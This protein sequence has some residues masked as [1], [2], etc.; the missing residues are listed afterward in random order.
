MANSPSASPEK[1]VFK[2]L[3]D[4]YLHFG[5]PVD[6][7]DEKTDFS[8]HNLKDI[9]A[10]LPYI[11]Q[12]FRPNFFSFVFVKNGSGKYTT[13][14]LVFDTVPGTIYF[15]NPGHYKSYHW[16][17]MEEVYLVTLSE[18]FLKENVHPDVFEEFPF[19][20]AET[21]QPRVLAEAEFAEFEQLYLQINKEYLA[22]S[23]YRNRI[24]GN[25][26][27]VLLLK[28]KEYFWKDYNP[29]YEGNRSSQIVKTFKLS[30]EKHYRDLISHK[31]EHVF[32]VQDYA[33]E[34]FLHPNYLSNVI[35]IKTGKPIGTWIAE[36]TIA[37]A[38][39]LLQNS[40]TSIKEL[41]WMLGFTEATHFS[42]YF[43]KHTG[44]SPV[45]YRKQHL[46]SS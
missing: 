26:F 38:K 29:I 25:L 44:T 20:L 41:A 6:D 12:T 17:Q 13:D 22:A 9:H 24:I 4:Q 35:K 46:S 30:L 7:I 40:A 36:K 43:K 14:D 3:R 39:S 27:V 8:I 19:L 42:N 21:V 32:R 1:L 16:K 45:L 28:I 23:P 31:V 33:D 10:T 34:Q 18:S 2:T 37:E 11:S 15:T 5:L